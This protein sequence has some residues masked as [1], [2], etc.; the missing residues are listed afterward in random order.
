MSVP[1]WDSYFMAMLPLVAAR[2][3]DPRTK[4]GCVVVGPHHEVRTT[5]YNGFPRGVQDT[6]PERWDRENGEK[7]FWVE[8]AERNAIYNAA[9]HGAALDGCTMYLNWLPCMDCAR[10]IIQSGIVRLVV[11]RQQHEKNRSAKW[12]ADF[13]RVETLLSEGGVSLNWWEAL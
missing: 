12:E 10:A 4:T 6:L 13:A 8:H 3:K 11:D 9:R 1:D 7:Y 2:S 5:G